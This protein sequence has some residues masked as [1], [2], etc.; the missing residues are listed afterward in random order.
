MLQ[1]PTSSSLRSETGHA[2]R[3]SAI[4]QPQNPASRYGYT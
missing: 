1:P 3:G 2:L 4:L